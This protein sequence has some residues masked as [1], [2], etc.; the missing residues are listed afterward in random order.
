MDFPSSWFSLIL[1]LLL[2]S[3]LHG[4][5][6][7]CCLS[8]STVSSDSSFL[9]TYIFSK[10][11]PLQMPSII[12]WHSDLYLQLFWVPGPYIQLPKKSFSPERWSYRHRLSMSKIELVI[13]YHSLPP[14]VFSASG[15]HQPFSCSNRNLKITCHFFIQQILM[16]H[17]TCTKQECARL[18]ESLYSCE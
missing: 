15:I 7:C 3:L 4:F 17:L 9:S 5:F 14:P 16:E 12:Q 8:P 10:V 11:S 6:W 13:S 2:L 18:R 1:C